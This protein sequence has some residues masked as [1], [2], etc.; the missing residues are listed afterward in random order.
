MSHAQPDK[1]TLATQLLAH[2]EALSRQLSDLGGQLMLKLDTAPAMSVVIPTAFMAPIPGMENIWW[3]QL[4][5]AYPENPTCTRLIVGGLA[6]SHSER[7]RVPHAVRLHLLEG[8][9]SF[10]QQSFG[11]ESDGLPAFR[12]SIAGDVWHL[13]EDEAHSYHAQTD[14]LM[15]NTYS[16]FF[17]V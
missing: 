9:L 11:Y 3:L 1:N 8:A 7:V 13:S 5:C 6:E 4:P 17:P 15:Y 12:R 16:P 10:W 2:G 14:F